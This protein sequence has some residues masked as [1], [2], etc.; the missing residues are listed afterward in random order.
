MTKKRLSDLLRQEAQKSLEEGTSAPEPN[1]EPIESKPATPVTP[2]AKAT[3]R[4]TKATSRARSPKST[5]TASTSGTKSASGAKSPV[6]ETA[7]GVENTSTQPEE[8][9]A[10]ALVRELEQAIAD[11]KAALTT[12]QATETGLRQEI[13]NL[14]SALQQQQDLVQTLKA[15]VASGDRYK[16][17]LEQTKQVILQ[18]S[19]QNIKVTQELDALRQQQKPSGSRS[20]NLELRKILEHPTLREQPST[21]FSDADIGWVD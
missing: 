21:A 5:P 15:E 20:T 13:A 2:T 3:T 16:A 18:L 7:P 11:L 17:E 6:V 12:A 10:A 14:E 19:D 8:K 4:S 1:S 9:Q